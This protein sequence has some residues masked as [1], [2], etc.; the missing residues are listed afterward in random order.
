[1]SILPPAYDDRSLTPAQIINAFG[2]AGRATVESEGWAVMALQ[3]KPSLSDFDMLQ[4]K[5]N[6]LGVRSVL[7]SDIALD[8]LASFENV[9]RSNVD[10]VLEE[11]GS[12]VSDFISYVWL[13]LAISEQVSQ[14]NVAEILDDALKNSL[15]WLQLDPKKR[16]LW[17]KLGE[18]VGQV[19]EKTGA[20]E[21][22]RW[23]KTQTSL[24]TS[25]RLD[26][27]A[28]RLAEIKLDDEIDFQD[29]FNFVDLVDESGILQSIVELP[30]APSIEVFDRRTNRTELSIDHIGLLKDWLRGRPIS[31][32][33]DTF[34]SQV[35]NLDFRYE[36]LGDYLTGWFEHHLSWSI[37]VL[38]ERAN[39]L[40]AQNE[41]MMLTP[42]FPINMS[43]FVRYGVSN[44]DALSLVM[45][46]IRSRYLAHTIVE[47]SKNR[48]EEQTIRSWLIE[49]G[50]TA[51]KDTLEATPVDLKDIMYFVR[52]TSFETIATIFEGG[53]VL[54][55]LNNIH[56]E[57]DVALGKK[58]IEDSTLFILALTT[59]SLNKFQ[60]HI[61]LI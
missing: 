31:E 14:L 27:L 33:A 49:Q 52:D 60:L 36:Q 56:E 23:S 39:T 46:G 4:P 55:P 8:Q 22:I 1:M 43:N 13:F 58:N 38:I 54:L 20:E 61:K 16:D 50:I 5:D 10:Q 24:S 7:T 59:T 57:G 40:V 37:G 17:K 53:E 35:K 15:A 26:I 9:L 44:E 19:Y 48:D 42:R 18:A 45:Q 3:S 12:H 25:R 21:R 2:R 47:T 32:L 51:W 34:F 29:P 41:F 11:G 28:K 6:A 30:E